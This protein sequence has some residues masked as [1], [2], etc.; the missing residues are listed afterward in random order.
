M[1]LRLSHLQQLSGNNLEKNKPHLRFIFFDKLSVF[2]QLICTSR[3]TFYFKKLL[4][5]S[6]RYEIAKI[7]K[8]KLEAI[9]AKVGWLII[10]LIKDANI[11]MSEI[12]KTKTDTFF[13]KNSP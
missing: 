1:I 4:R 2:I 7:S 13:I 11:S 10:Q 9:I 8:P 5:F 3:R 12:I 6:Q